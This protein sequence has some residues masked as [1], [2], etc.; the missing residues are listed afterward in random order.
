MPASSQLDLITLGRLAEGIR[1]CHQ[2]PESLLI[3]SGYS[4]LGLESQASVVRRA[5]ISLGFDSL[6][7]ETL[8][9]PRTTEEEA[10]ELKQAFGTNANVILVTDAVHMPR[11]M[12]LFKEQG[13]NPVPAPTNYIVK[14]GPN[15]GYLKWLPSVKNITLTDRV[16]H[17][18][19]GNIKAE[20]F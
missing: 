5:A 20:V 6:R 13:F 12:R 10:Q 18:F 3:C 15:Q 17:E 1:I 16:L 14:D 19:L 8:T 9:K 7:I 11:A 2:I 4:S